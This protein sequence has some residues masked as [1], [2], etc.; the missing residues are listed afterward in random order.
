MNGVAFLDATSKT[1]SIKETVENV[2]FMTIKTSAL[3]K[4][5]AREFKSKL[6][7]WEEIFA[8]D[9]SDKGL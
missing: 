2:H 1:Q 8:E 5:I 6:T 3:R 4:T 7:D 9:T